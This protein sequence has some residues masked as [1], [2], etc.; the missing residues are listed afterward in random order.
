MKLKQ[1]YIF[2]LNF[3]LLCLLSSVALAAQFKSITW[4]ME[5]FPSG[6]VNMY[7]PVNEP[8]KIKGNRSRRLFAHVPA[9]R[10]RKR[11]EYD[12]SHIQLT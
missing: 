5:W 6:L 4:N 1:L 3:V 10:M 2:V 8:T 11:V 12:P 9:R 7:D